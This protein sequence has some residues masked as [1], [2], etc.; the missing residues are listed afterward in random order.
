MGFI[1]RGELRALSKAAAT[2]A[3]SEYLEELLEQDR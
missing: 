2:T 1:S 3:D